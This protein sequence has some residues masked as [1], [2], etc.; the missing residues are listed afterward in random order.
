MIAGRQ[1]H[2]AQRYAKQRGKN[3]PTRAP[4]MYLAPVLCDDDG[5]DRNRD[6]HGQ[7]SSDANRK[8]ERK[9]RNSDEGLAKSER[10]IESA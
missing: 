2:Q 7:R 1:Q 5:S 6:E 3:Q 4:H 9:K 8:A 10:R